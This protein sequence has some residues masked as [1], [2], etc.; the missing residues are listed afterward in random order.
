MRDPVCS[1]VTVFASRVWLSWSWPTQLKASEWPSAPKPRPFA[2][3]SVVMFTLLDDVTATAPVAKISAP[4]CSCAVVVYAT[5]IVVD[6]AF[7]TPMPPPP[8]ARVDAYPLLEFVA[9]IVKLA[10]VMTRA[11]PAMYAVLVFVCVIVVSAWP[12]PTMP[13]VAFFELVAMFVVPE[14]VIDT[15]LPATT[16]DEP[17]TYA[18]TLCVFVTF[19][20]FAP[21]AIAPPPEPDEVADV[22]PSP[23]GGIMTPSGVPPGAR[24][25]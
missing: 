2:S 25:W 22:V 15:L 6:S 16:S 14:L 24:I 20:R 9:F 21:A 19:A 11:L 17:P 13:P 10:P 7:A 23:A 1:S 12:M 5:S 3:E 4:D 18:D 8:R